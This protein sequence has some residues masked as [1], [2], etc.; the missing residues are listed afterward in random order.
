MHVSYCCS[1]WKS[2]DSTHGNARKRQFGLQSQLT[3][4]H[5]VGFWVRL[6]LGLEDINLVLCESWP[7]QVLTAFFVLVLQ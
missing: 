3:L 6:E 4:D 2:R 7:C 1:K 5:A